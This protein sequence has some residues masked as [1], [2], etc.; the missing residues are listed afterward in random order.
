MH[1]MLS[2]KKDC[3]SLGG[4]KCLL[5]EILDLFRSL[6]CACDMLQRLD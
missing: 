3:M 2:I 1:V 4:E 5:L 6:V